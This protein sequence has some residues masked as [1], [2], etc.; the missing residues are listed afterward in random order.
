MRRQIRSILVLPL[1]L[2]TLGLAYGILRAAE[3]R[4]Q[5]A[6]K[7]QVI[8]T[9]KLVSAKYGDN[10]EN[11]A[12]KLGVTLKHVTPVGF[13]W[14]SYDSESKVVSRTSGGTYSIK[15]DQYEEIPQYGLSADFDITRE[16][17]QS[18][19]IKIEGDTWHHNGTLSNGLKIDEVWERCKTP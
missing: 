11:V 15:G 7:D 2:G 14:V 18:F 17:V 19:R 16:K 12:P 8:G 13:M 10:E 9:W 4:D 3:E 5:A 1:I 6:V